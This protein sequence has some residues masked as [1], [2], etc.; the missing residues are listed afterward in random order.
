MLRNRFMI[1]WDGA[2]GILQSGWML[3]FWSIAV[4]VGL[5]QQSTGSVIDHLFRFQ[6]G[7]PYLSQ[8]NLD[9]M[10][11]M[12]WMLPHLLLA[13]A[14]GKYHEDSV[15]LYRFAVARWGSIYRWWRFQCAS[16]YLAATVYYLLMYAAILLILGV[17]GLSYQPALSV[18]GH[19]Y[20]DLALMFVCTIV[21]MATLLTIQLAVQVIT[22]N[23]KAAIGSFLFC[24]V[25]SVF[26]TGAAEKYGIGSWFMI[27]RSDLYSGPGGYQ[28]GYAV[29]CCALIIVATHLITFLVAKLRNLNW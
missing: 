29:G 7:I 16:V 3:S 27:L 6:G 28:I 17:M 2:K 26:L 10:R 11:L 14:I 13:A 19:E 9:L 18:V 12:T 4:V 15:F 20:V 24:I 1:V 21:V 8:E 5:M 22:H 23:G 25:I